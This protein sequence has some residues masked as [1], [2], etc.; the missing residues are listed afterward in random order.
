VKAKSQKKLF[1]EL[2]PAQAA[3]VNGGS[4]N[5]SGVDAG[6]SKR[7]FVPAYYGSGSAT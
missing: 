6:N 1:V 4:G 5:N 3:T 2:T 7:K